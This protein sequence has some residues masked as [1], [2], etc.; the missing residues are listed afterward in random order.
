MRIAVASDNGVSIAEHF[1]RCAG[2]IVYEY[3]NDEV[4]EIENRP[5]GNSQHHDQHECTNHG[6]NHEA[7]NHGHE[8]F[9]AVLGDCQMVICRG[10][11]RR[12]IVDLESRGIKPA[13]IAG[14][15]PAR[16]AVE[17]LIKG[18]LGFNNQSSCCNH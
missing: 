11:G 7:A 2:F 17:L 16:E 14:D 8:S 4:K 10:M 3:A 15:I 6:H 12:A 1:G 9:L 18:K 5:N 13:I